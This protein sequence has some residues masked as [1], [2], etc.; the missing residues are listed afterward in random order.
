MVVRV[1]I[2]MYYLLE[3]KELLSYSPVIQLKFS[4]KISIL[5]KRDPAIVSDIWTNEIHK[6]HGFLQ[7]QNMFFIGQSSNSHFY[8]F[9]VKRLDIIYYFVL[10]CLTK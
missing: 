10:V 6:L 8:S 1:G 4:F 2:L 3:L 7:L 9:T 5:L